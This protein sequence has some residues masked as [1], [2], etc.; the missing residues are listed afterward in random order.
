[1][2]RRT[3]LL[4]APALAVA[5]PS[6]RAERLLAMRLKF[7]IEAKV[8]PSGLLTPSPLEFTPEV[9]AALAAGT[10]EIR[11]RY[12]F[13]IAGRDVLAIQVF[14]VP[15][16]APYPL[17]EPPAPADPSSV[18]YFE[19][20]VDEVLLADRPNAIVA[21]AGPVVSTPGSPFGD[22]TGVLSYLNFQYVPGPPLRFRAVFG[23]SAGVITTNAASGAGTLEWKFQMP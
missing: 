17:P 16:S 5:V 20:R 23:G 9:G 4:A 7:D 19:V 11:V 14:L 6:A 18:A 15:P 22:L 8:P 13:P 1:M 21:M 3:W 12:R 2:N 10:L